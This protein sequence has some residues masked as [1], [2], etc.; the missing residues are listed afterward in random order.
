MFKL[1]VVVF[2]VALLS[3]K[4]MY[5]FGQDYQKSDCAQNVISLEQYDQCMKSNQVPYEDCQEER[6]AVVRDMS[7]ETKEQR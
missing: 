5:R 7:E 2:A 6:E 4:E 1:M 3:A